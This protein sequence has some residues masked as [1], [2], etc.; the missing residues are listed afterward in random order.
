MQQAVG[1]LCVFA[2]GAAF[3]VRLR[4]QD[5]LP[6]SQQAPLFVTALSHPLSLPSQAAS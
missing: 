6:R 4:E 1:A 3:G 2:F 5:A